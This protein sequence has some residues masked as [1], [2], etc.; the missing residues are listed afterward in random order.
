MSGLVIA[1]KDGT[2][3]IQRV[4]SSLEASGNA[5]L[6]AEANLSSVSGLIL[7]EVTQTRQDIRTISRIDGEIA[8]KIDALHDLMLLQGSAS[9]RAQLGHEVFLSHQPHGRQKIP[10]NEPLGT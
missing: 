1:Q 3:T 6:R 10:A 8:A 7:A 2:A 9:E 4:E 5:L